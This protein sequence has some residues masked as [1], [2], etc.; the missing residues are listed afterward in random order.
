MARLA[1]VAIVG[2]F[3]FV[4]IAALAGVAIGLVVG[5]IVA[6]MAHELHFPSDPHGSLP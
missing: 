2:G 4:V 6:L 3:V 1:V 5:V